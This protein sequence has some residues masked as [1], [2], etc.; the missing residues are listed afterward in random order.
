MDEKM[1]DEK[2]EI[3]QSHQDF[4]KAVGKLARE[5]NL[6]RFG[7]SFRP[8]FGDPWGET[9]EFSWEQ[10]RHGEDSDQ[11]KIWSTKRVNTRIGPVRS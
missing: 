5:H 8:G 7:G 11:I 4:C 1:A 2:I 9:I 10:G 3:P 6:E